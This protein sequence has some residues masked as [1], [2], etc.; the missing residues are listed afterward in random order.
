ML[1]RLAHSAGIVGKLFG[2][3]LVSA[4]A[5][6]GLPQQAAAAGTGLLQLLG[7]SGFSTNSHDIFNVHKHSPE[8]NWNTGFDFTPDNYKK[9]NHNVSLEKPCW[10]VSARHASNSSR[11]A[12][13]VS[14]SSRC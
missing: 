5:A 4:G 9:V 13:R 6:A 2:Q 12:F 8:N 11:V 14:G 3:Q 10:C 1:G 7:R